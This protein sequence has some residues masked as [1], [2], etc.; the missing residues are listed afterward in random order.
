MFAVHRLWGARDGG[1][2]RVTEP[3]DDGINRCSV[4]DERRCDQD[5]IA[6]AAVR[7]PAHRVDQQIALHG[8]GLY[9][10][11][12]PALGLEWPLIR[13][14]GY[15]LDAP[16][17]APTAYITDERMSVEARVQG[18]AKLRAPRAHA[19]EQSG[20]SHCLLHGQRRRARQRV[21]DIRMAVLEA[22]RAMG[23][24]VE[25]GRADK[26]RAH[27]RIAAESMRNTPS[28]PTASG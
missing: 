20:A 5:M 2:D 18:V 13:A 16:E 10:H 26:H 1:V 3:I 15:E 19:I 11:V 22:G 17:Q 23:E 25:Y 27:W 9:P 28:P 6:G 21:A 4:T 8:L 14:L 12:Y 24:G 7:G